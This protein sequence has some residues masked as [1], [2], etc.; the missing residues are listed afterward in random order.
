MHNFLHWLYFNSKKA[1]L[2]TSSSILSEYHRTFFF[3]ERKKIYRENTKKS[4]KPFCHKLTQK[5]TYL[6]YHPFM[7]LWTKHNIHLFVVYF[8]RIAVEVSKHI[9]RSDFWLPR[10][11]DDDWY[12]QAYTYFHHHRHNTKKEVKKEKWS[13]PRKEPI[14]I[15]HFFSCVVLHTFIHDCRLLSK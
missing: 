1:K 11:D 15:L 4:E 13:H 2:S 10:F 8:P 9:I 3:R 6:L 12:T 14:V 7:C 5:Y